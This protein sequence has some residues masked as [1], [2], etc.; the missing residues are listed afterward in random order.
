MNIPYISTRAPWDCTLGLLGLIVASPVIYLGL[1]AV[2]GGFCGVSSGSLLPVLTTVTE[3]TYPQ[4]QSGLL[5]AINH[6]FMFLTMIWAVSTVLATFAAIS[7]GNEAA[8]VRCRQGLE[9]N[10]VASSLAALMFALAGL[11]ECIATWGR[12]I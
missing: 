2:V 1:S 6:L 11:T 8:R 5:S 12:A 3:G 7:V 10:A 9:L 4:L